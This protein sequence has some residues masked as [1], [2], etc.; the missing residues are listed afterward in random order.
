MTN[1]TNT[2][3]P[4]ADDDRSAGLLAWQ[5]AHYSEGHTR[6]RNLVVHVITAP[7]FCIGTVALL[8]APFVSAWLALGALLMIVTLAAQ[9]R[10]HGSE[11]SRPKP[12]RGPLDFV[13]R[14]F[15]EQWITFPRFVVS[16]GLA[17]AWRS[18]EKSSGVE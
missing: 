18:Q 10:G 4:L 2:T 17:R 16:G 3:D 8:A 12:F 11:S 7:L 6:R 14:F 9:G 1:T 15:A 5:L 13:A